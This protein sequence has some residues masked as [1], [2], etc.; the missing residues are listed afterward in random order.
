MALLSQSTLLVCQASIQPLLPTLVQSLRKLGV[1]GIRQSAAAKPPKTDTRPSDFRFCRAQSIAIAPDAS[2]ACVVNTL[3]NTIA[4]ID[5]QTTRAGNRWHNIQEPRQIAIAPNAAFAL[6]IDG[7]DGVTRID[8]PN[9]GTT[10]YTGFTQP[11]HVVIAPDSSFAIVIGNGQVRHID[12]RTRVVSFL[13]GNV[14]SFA[15]HVSIASN[16]EFA[17]VCNAGS[18]GRIDFNPCTGT[19]AVSF[20]YRVITK[21]TRVNATA[22]APDMSFALVGTGSKV[23]RI[24]IR[25]GVVSFPYAV[26]AVVL[27]IKIAPNGAFALLCCSDRVIHISLGTGFVRVLTDDEPLA[28]AIAPDASFALVSTATNVGR[29]GLVGNRCVLEFP[30]A[31]HYCALVVVTS[32]KPAT[33]SAYATDTAGWDYIQKERDYEERRRHTQQINDQYEAQRRDQ[34]MQSFYRATEEINRASLE[35]YRQCQVWAATYS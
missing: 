15:S 31:L 14:L 33:A 23:G 1:M 29:I 18:V 11:V 26:R 7:I 20:P 17:L 12:I 32:T 8:L 30:Y 6:V 34:E 24:N 19:D 28:V 16:G 3:I 22:I 27:D 5:L 9:G 4:H 10:R 35:G 13:Y 25:T 2:F 21:R